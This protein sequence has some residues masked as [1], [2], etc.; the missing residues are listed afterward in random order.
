MRY[1]AGQKIAISQGALILV[2][3]LESEAVGVRPLYGCDLLLPLLAIAVIAKRLTTRKGVELS[4]V[5]AE[6]A[7]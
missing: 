4:D 2:C 5:Q 1:G 7:P 3:P 6:G